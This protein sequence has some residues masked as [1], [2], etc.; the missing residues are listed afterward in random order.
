MYWKLINSPSFLTRFPDMHYAI[1]FR[2]FGVVPRSGHGSVVNVTT[3]SGWPG[4]W[5]QWSPIQV[6]ST[7]RKNY[8]YYYF[9]LLFNWHI[10]PDITPGWAESYIGLQKKNLWGLL[11]G[12][13]TGQIAF[14]SSRQQRQSTKRKCSSDPEKQF[15]FTRGDVTNEHWLFRNWWLTAQA[16]LQNVE[17]QH[18]TH[19]NWPA[20]T[21]NIII[22][23]KY[24]WIRQYQLQLLVHS[25]EFKI[26]HHSVYPLSP[27]S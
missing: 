9:Q 22:V 26:T 16:I 6:T 25:N 4:V 17:S 18:V 21:V 7:I 23:S 8:Y 24:P 12:Y 1:M 5:F 20:F 3:C 15:H 10:F 27:T 11:A 13:F 14:L 2:V 19:S